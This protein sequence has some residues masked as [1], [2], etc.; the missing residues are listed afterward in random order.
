MSQIFKWYCKMFIHGDSHYLWNND[1]CVY[2]DWRIVQRPGNSNT[3]WLNVTQTEWAVVSGTTVT[4]ILSICTHTPSMYVCVNNRRIVV[5]MLN[6]WPTLQSLC[7]HSMTARRREGR[8]K[9][10]RRRE[11]GRKTYTEGNRSAVIIF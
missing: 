10:G 5:F 11:R 8:D 3:E 2:R 1:L 7:G 6:I 9:T 4:T